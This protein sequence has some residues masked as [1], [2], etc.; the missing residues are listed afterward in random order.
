MQSTAAEM[1]W[2]RRDRK[3]R[4]RARLLAVG[5][6]S[7]VAAGTC[8]WVPELLFAAPAPPELRAPLRG[9]TG[10]GNLHNAEVPASLPSASASLPWAGMVAPAALMALAALQARAEGMACGAFRLPRPRR[11]PLKMGQTQ[12]RESAMNMAPRLLHQTRT[13]EQSS[14][15]YA[16]AAVMATGFFLWYAA[17]VSFNIVN[18]Q[19]LGLFPHAWT[20]SVVQLATVVACSAVGWAT[21]AIA[22]PFKA[23][24]PGFLWRLL[25]AA[26]CHALGN[27]LTSVAFSCGSVSFTH[28]VKTSEPVWMALGNLLITG[29]RLPLP[30][31]LALVPIMAGVALASAGELSFTWVGFLAALGSTICFAGRGI[32]SKRLMTKGADGGPS[33]SPLNVYAM[34]SLLALVFTL[35][36]ALLADGPAMLSGG[37]GATVATHG[38]QVA[39]LLAVTGLSY[40]AYNAI[41]F[42][43][44]AKLDVVSHAV[45]NL[46]KRIFVIGFSVA[47][48]NTPLTLRAALGSTVA[49]LGSGLYSYVKATAGKK[50]KVIAAS[51]PPAPAAAAA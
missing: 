46:G 47:V 40:Y 22:S 2:A 27:G 43:L 39:A 15:N 25:P 35:P 33:M 28:V 31:L 37:L 49:I 12:L 36:V 18:K 4:S 42:K 9:A 29:A 50:P 44:L 26:I 45:G 17:N 19:A 48:F 14:S 20:V 13:E 38:A 23:M 24:G 5:C 6:A 32:F 1:S 7:A 30:Q 8:R 10:H 34:D 21:G 41:A 3:L 16:G 11:G 51:A